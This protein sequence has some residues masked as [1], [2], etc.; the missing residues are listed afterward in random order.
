MIVRRFW[1]NSLGTSL[2][3]YRGQKG[4][5]LENSEKS[6]KR[7]SRG[8]SE[9]KLEKESRMTIFQVFFRVF[10]SFSTL[11]RVFLTPGPRGPGNPFSNFFRSFLGRGLFD[12]CRRPT[13]SQDYWLLARVCCFFPRGGLGHCRH[14]SNLQVL[15]VFSSR[16][17]SAYGETKIGNEM[18]LA[19]VACIVPKQSQIRGVPKSEFFGSQKRGD[20]G[21]GEEGRSGG[22]VNRA[23][24]GKRVE[25]WG[26]R[27]GRKGARKGTRKTLILVPL[28]FRYSLVAVQVPSRE[29]PN[30]RW[31]PSWEP[32]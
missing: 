20:K 19:C 1:D 6:L 24:R 5:S 13:M 23:W 14:S 10:D 16:W 9:K 29:S 30:F 2:A 28:W 17:F 25:K 3:F 7:G 11:F 22:R 32:N 21:G 8:L 27:G 26:K 15:A 4:P 31:V 12:P 18:Q